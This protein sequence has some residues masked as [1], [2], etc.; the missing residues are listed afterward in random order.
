M[1]R[2]ETNIQTKRRQF[3]D[4]I[5]GEL[6][7]QKKTQGDLAFFIGTTQPNV[8][9]KIRGKRDWTLSEY[10]GVFEYFGWDE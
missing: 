8:S 1:A 4:R 7:R 2:T 9:L 5:R 6:A 10:F 3:N